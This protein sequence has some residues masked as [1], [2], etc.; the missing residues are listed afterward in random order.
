MY[1][2]LADE[3]NR[4]PTADCKFFVYGGLLL[5]IAKLSELH[6]GVEL[7]RKETGYQPGD[8]L[9]FDTRERPAHVAVE[10]ATEA[11]QKVVSLC[12]DLGCR[13]IAHVILHDIIKNQDPDQH[14]LWAADSVIGRFHKYL[15]NV[16]GDDG[17]V[18][19][20][21]L[22]VKGQ[23]QYL[24]DKFGRGLHL[25]DGTDKALSRIK[26]F[27]ASC[28]GASH[29]NSAMDIVLGSF[30]YCINNP[31]NLDAAKDMMGAVMTLMWHD[32]IGDDLYIVNR[33]LIPRPRIQDIQV[34]TYKEEY[35]RLF[36][37]INELIRD[38]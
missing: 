10:K 29:A 14:I 12:I 38:L 7:I 30:R 20:D 9:K 34:D 2:L 27:A 33:G 26:L 5:P 11:K 25:P 32:R 28:V 21:N 35:K 1:I 16:A 8:I 3:T 23:F 24:S 37:Q 15:D 31:K 4:R 19:V 17:I 6:S 36:D 22:P 13:F 18:V